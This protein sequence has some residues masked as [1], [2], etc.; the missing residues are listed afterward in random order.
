MC[1]LGAGETENKE[2]RMGIVV[3]AFLGLMKVVGM[4]LLPFVANFHSFLLGLLQSTNLR[5]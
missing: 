1:N 3:H 4:L 2:L 5:G